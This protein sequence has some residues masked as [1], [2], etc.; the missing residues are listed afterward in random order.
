MRLTYPAYVYR[1]QETSF[2]RILDRLDLETSFA[3]GEVEQS[4][5]VGWDSNGHRFTLLW[6]GKR[7]CSNA[8]IHGLDLNGLVRSVHN[9]SARQERTTTSAV[10]PSL[11]GRFLT[12]VAARMLCCETRSSREELNPPSAG[13]LSPL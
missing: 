4:Q 11:M 3:K 5:L 2:V 9:Y 1:Q 8:R 13:L 12:Q 6:N 10:T 7:E